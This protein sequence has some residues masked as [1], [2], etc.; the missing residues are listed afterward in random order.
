VG[1]L[2]HNDDDDNDNDNTKEGQPMRTRQGRQGRQEETENNNCATGQQ[3]MLKQVL[4]TLPAVDII[5]IDS[6]KIVSYFLVFQF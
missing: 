6:G 4:P 5:N 2:Q 3:W 1:S